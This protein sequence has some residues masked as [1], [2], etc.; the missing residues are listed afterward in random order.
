M[1]KIYG[2]FAYIEIKDF[3]LRGNRQNQ[4]TDGINR[5]TFV[6]QQ[7]KQRNINRKMGKLGEQAVYR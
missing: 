6:S 2:W 4:Q 7:E 1:A 3:C 5:K